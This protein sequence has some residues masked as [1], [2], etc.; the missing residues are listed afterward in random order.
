VFAE[1]LRERLGSIIELSPLQIEQLEKH[2]EL[3]NRWNR[4]LNLT[5]LRKPEELVE[6]H[7]C[8]SLFLASHLPDGSLRIADVGSG[9]GFPGIPAAIAKPG[10]CVALIESHQRKAVFLREAIRELAN[11]KVLAVRAEN[12][13]DTFEWVMSRAVRFTEIEKV[14]AKLAPNVAILGGDECP[15][16]ACFTWNNPIRIPWGDQRKLWLGFLRST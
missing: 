13:R 11:I 5:S 8:E 10:S 12:V 1:L 7:Y 9:A 14:A 2:F 6:R 16:D 4:V 3:L 15:N